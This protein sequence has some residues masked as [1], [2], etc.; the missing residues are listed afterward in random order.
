M[1]ITYNVHAD[2]LLY[3]KEEI[4]YVLNLDHVT[5]EMLEGWIGTLMVSNEPTLFTKPCVTAELQ[6]YS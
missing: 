5:A 2:L 1:T 3:S 6:N 4:E